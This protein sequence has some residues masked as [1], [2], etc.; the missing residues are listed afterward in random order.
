[1]PLASHEPLITLLAAMRIIPGIL[2]FS[3]GL[4]AGVLV[5]HLS[6]TVADSPSQLPIASKAP[7]PAKSSSASPAAK[8]PTLINPGYAKSYLHADSKQQEKMLSSIKP[9]ERLDYINYLLSRSGAAG[10]DYTLRSAI[11]KL[12]KMQMQANPS[13]TID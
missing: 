3:A 9:A 5:T 1:M 11:G 8:G 10:L 2:L 7:A 13:S 12:L 6:L 4:L